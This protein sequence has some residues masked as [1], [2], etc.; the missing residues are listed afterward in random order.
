MKK[1]MIFIFLMVAIS[2]FAQ[3]PISLSVTPTNITYNV[4]YPAYFNP[5]EPDQQP[6]LFRLTLN[7]NL[8]NNNYILQC[9]MQ[10]QDSFAEAVLTPD[11][12]VPDIVVITNRDIIVEAGSTLYFTVSSNFDDFL[13]DIE[14]QI[15]ETGRMPDGNYIFTIQAFEPGHPGEENYALSNKEICVFTIISPVSISL[16]T[17]GNPIGLGPAI[18]SNNYPNFVW[19]SNLTDYTIRIY[20]LEEE[21]ATAEEIEQLEPFFEE[22]NYPSTSFLY[23]T[24][25]PDFPYNKTHAWQISAEI[26]CPVA[27]ETYKSIIY[28]FMLSSEEGEMNNQTLINFLTQLNIEGINELIA[29]IEGGFSFENMIWEGRE[30]TMDELNDILEKISN[31]EL[32]IKSLTVE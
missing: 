30:I 18:I 32:T 19:F 13:D 22:Q 3:Y 15:R 24:Y 27:T 1:L 23:P 10:W 17:P 21:S 12:N 4:F 5:E 8:G 11:E 31:G 29:L 2:L 28:L 25:A 26:Q 9:T 7:N 6:L 14:E 20:Q 16:I